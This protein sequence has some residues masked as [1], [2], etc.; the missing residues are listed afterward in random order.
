V[1]GSVVLC[2]WTRQDCSWSYVSLWLDGNQSDVVLFVNR[3]LG[4]NLDV[5]AEDDSLVNSGAELGVV[6]MLCQELG[7]FSSIM[8]LLYIGVL[9]GQTGGWRPLVLSLRRRGKR[10]PY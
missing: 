5:L 10:A 1:N 3:Q 9:L 7:I 4:A 2:D 6:C 8:K